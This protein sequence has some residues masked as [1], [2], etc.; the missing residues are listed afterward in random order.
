MAERLNAARRG[1]SAALGLGSPSLVLLAGSALVKERSASRRPH[2]TFLAPARTYAWAWWWRPR[3]VGAQRH[4][5]LRPRGRGRW[6]TLDLR[7]PECLSRHVVCGERERRSAAFCAA[8]PAP[9]PVRSTSVFSFQSGSGW[10]EGEVERRRDAT[11]WPVICGRSSRPGAASSK[12]RKDPVLRTDGDGSPIL[13]DKRNGIF[14]ADAVV[15]PWLGVGRSRSCNS[16]FAAVRHPPCLPARHHL[17]DRKKVQKEAGLS[18]S[19][20]LLRLSLDVTLPSSPSPLYRS[21]KLGSWFHPYALSALFF[22]LPLC[23]LFS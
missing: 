2:G 7:G 19:R 3:E 23:L 9:C 14:S 16:L 11:K 4:W 10:G 18:L 5:L 17:P 21:C 6:A 12:L 20:S 13:P 15:K 22:G 1:N 8:G